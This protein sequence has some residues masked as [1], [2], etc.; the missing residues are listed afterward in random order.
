MLKSE[1]RIPLSFLSKYPLES[2]AWFINIQL[3]LLDFNSCH[4]QRPKCQ[5]QLIVCAILTKTLKLTGFELH[6]F[7]H[8]GDAG[9][10]YQKSL[11]RYGVI[12]NVMPSA[13]VLY[14]KQTRSLSPRFVWIQHSFE[15]RMPHLVFNWMSCW[16]DNSGK[17][18]GRYSY[19]S[20]ILWVPYYSP[21]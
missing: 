8:N 9:T 2:P 17:E 12:N 19:R 3:L 16:F 21:P 7:L 1:E 4:K 13:R 18:A 15:M 14:T 11:Y 20:L 10:R 6:W 5:E